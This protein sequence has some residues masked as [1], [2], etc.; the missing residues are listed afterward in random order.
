MAK[1][2]IAVFLIL[3]LLMGAVVLRAAAA[4][5]YE[6]TSFTELTTTPAAATYAGGVV[7][8]PDGNWIILS[9][10]LA[11][12]DGEHITITGGGVIQR[13]SG[14]TGALISVPETSTLTL[15]NIAIDGGASWSEAIPTD[16]GNSGITASAPAIINEGTLEL[17]TVTIGT[18]S[19]PAVIRNND[20]H[21]SDGGAVYNNGGE[22]IL[23]DTVITGCL[24]VGNGGAIYNNDGYIHGSARSISS[25][26]A[27][28]SG[29][30]IAQAGP[31]A[32][33]TIQ[34][35]TFAVN[36][37]VFNGGALYIPEGQLAIS[38]GTFSTNVAG[39][40]GGGVYADVT[41]VMSG[42]VIIKNNVL[43]SSAKSN[44]YLASTGVAVSRSSAM[45][46]NSSIGLSR[47]TANMMDDKTMVTPG[48][49]SFVPGDLTAFFLD[50][51]SAYHLD[52]NIDG[53]LIVLA[54]GAQAPDPDET[55]TA[56]TATT[57]PGGS[58]DDH[59][60]RVRRVVGKDDKNGAADDDDDD[61]TYFDTW[62][63]AVAYANFEG[64]TAS[65]S[66]CRTAYVSL[67]A[68]VQTTNVTVVRT[69]WVLD[70]SVTSGYDNTVHTYTL[71]TS[72]APRLL[73][74]SSDAADFAQ[75]KIISGNFI[76]RSDSVDSV[77]VYADESQNT[78]PYTCASDCECIVNGN[79]ECN[80]GKIEIIG[81]TIS[82]TNGSA[83]VAHDRLE[84]ADFVD[85]LETGEDALESRTNIIT[86]SL[87]ASAKPAVVATGGFYSD[88]GSIEA[89]GGGTALQIE[90]AGNRMQATRVVTH[91]VCAC[92]ASCPCATGA[93][94]HEAC[95]GDECRCDCDC[96]CSCDP[97]ANPAILINS[98]GGENADDS[99][100]EI[101]GCTITHTGIGPAITNNSSSFILIREP[102]IHG[103]ETRGNSIITGRIVS[104]SWPRANPG[105]VSREPI[106]VE[107]TG[108][109]INTGNAVVYAYPDNVGIPDVES[110][111]Y[112][113]N[114]TGYALAEDEGEHALV[115]TDRIPVRFCLERDGSVWQTYYIRRGGAEFYT[116]ALGT[117]RA[118]ILPTA[119][120][121]DFLGWH[122]RGVVDG[123]ADDILV[124]DESGNLCV[125][126]D[127]YTDLLGLWIHEDQNVAELYAMW[128][129]QGGSIYELTCEGRAYIVDSEGNHLKR[130]VY[131]AG[132]VIDIATPE[133]YQPFPGIN[134]PFETWSSSNGGTF[135]AMRLPATSFI[136]PANDTT[137]RG[138]YQSVSIPHVAASSG[139]S[140]S[141][142]T[143]AAPTTADRTSN[144]GGEGS[145]GGGG[146]VIQE[147]AWDFSNF[148]DS[149]LSFFEET[150]SVRP[151]DATG[152][153][154]YLGDPTLDGD[155]YYEV[156]IDI[157]IPQLGG[158]FDVLLLTVIGM[159]I[160]LTA[161]YIS[162]KRYYA[163]RVKWSTSYRGYY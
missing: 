62:D 147:G 111:L 97:Y 58:S 154:G 30:A 145:G 1:R 37:A 79:C 141:Q 77:T 125:G 72:T 61:Y 91:C 94:I 13:K 60:A 160:S 102:V 10:T 12:P 95:E 152:P 64:V 96:T 108:M 75:L 3:T 4:G 142:A 45:T 42:L 151:S 24:S 63:E 74:V 107:I 82:C 36:T 54:A 44:L 21:I 153:D 143:T 149:V 136:M 100:L 67:L 15:H 28:V 41:P 98:V 113:E 11:I 39:A 59:V 84:M 122:V 29:G 159:M 6:I 26:T 161:A 114:G 128:V 123:I 19:K 17:S 71:S 105:F 52:F 32:R 22:I 116:Q 117:E 16:T 131:A 40:L 89:L 38:G 101:A 56:T 119:D 20:N 150:A 155:N 110:F 35:G 146:N 8:I 51:G 127:S 163:S 78:T 139:G 57:T 109:T 69:H 85:G 34:G 140:T 49:G 156:D 87:A 138:V 133:S 31:N 23:N 135:A 157:P 5:N 14:F 47:D 48:S 99:T 158:T 162:L 148:D 144:G 46:T 27:L 50:D 106:P 81:G 80:N 7:T 130:G 93:C 115:Y 134:A 70:D 76:N 90:G 65:A 112:Y 53:D 73:E 66:N 104:H 2:I 33:L 43:A 9:G 83:V 92:A 126:V 132:D 86:H 88:G 55:T 118:D 103:Q 120:R 25:N 137:I 121:Q 124:I 18:E 129:P 68:D